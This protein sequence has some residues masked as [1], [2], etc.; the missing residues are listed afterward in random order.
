M[1]CTWWERGH[2]QHTTFGSRGNILWFECKRGTL[3]PKTN[4]WHNWWYLLKFNEHF[5]RGVDIAIFFC[6]DDRWS[7][8]HGRKTERIS[9]INQGKSWSPH[10]EITL[11]N[12]PI[13]ISNSDLNEVM[14]TVV[15]IVNFIV[16]RSSLTHRQFQSLLEEMDCTLKDIPLHSAVSWLSCGKVLERFVGCLVL[17]L[18]WLKKAK[19]T[20]N[21]KI[22]N[23]FLSDNTGHFN[24][25]NLWLQGAEQTALNMF[26]TWAAH[27]TWK[28]SWLSSRVQHC[29]QPNLQNCAKSWKP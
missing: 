28:C 15:K 12:T 3:L 16:K 1:V 26:E 6:N 2:K 7:S 22:R 18:S 11:H 19:S 21:S 10:N 9:Q 17:K 13:K 24:E 25:L 5:E 27:G 20:L 29:G 14:A 23:L 4:D 8:C